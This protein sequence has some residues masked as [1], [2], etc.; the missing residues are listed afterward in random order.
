MPFFDRSSPRIV[1]RV[2]GPGA[3]KG[4]FP[5]ELVKPDGESRILSLKYKEV[6]KGAD[7]AVLEIDNY[8]LMYPDMPTFDQGSVVYLSWGYPSIMAAEREMVVVDWTPGPSFQV[9]LL[10]RSILMNRQQVNQTYNGVKYSDVA[11]TIAARNGYGADVQDIED[12]DVVLEHVLQPS[13][14]DAQLM[15]YIAGKAG[16]VF[17]VDETGFHFHE[18]R[19]TAKPRAVYEYF[20]DGSG[21]MLEHPK[22][23]KA[24]RAQPGAVTLKGKDAQTGKPFA[25]RADNQ[26]IAGREGAAPVML[27]FDKQTGK[28]ILLPD[29]KAAAELTAGTSAANEG[30]AKKQAASLFKS[31]TSNP[32]TGTVPIVG[33]PL[34]KAKSMFEMKGLGKRLSGNYY[35]KEVEHDVKPGDYRM[36]VK[37][38][39]D[40]LSAGAGTGAKTPTSA[41]KTNTQPGYS[42]ADGEPLKET[43][44][45]DKDTG[46]NRVLYTPK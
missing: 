13:W 38:M 44:V 15:R 7:T 28:D 8:D 10:A 29:P 17:F 14:T 35:A 3:P 30:E 31:A 23:D 40:G 45:F 33:D 46:K 39:R 18:R 2:K 9:D 41:G 4:T 43:L 19:W 36:N 6:E 20:T 11:R 24:P 42:S 34:F 5:S 27:V 32:K 1:I 12:T 21:D 26:S 25:V 37:F 16:K 22:F